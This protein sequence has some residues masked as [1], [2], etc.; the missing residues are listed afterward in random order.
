MELTRGAEPRAAVAALYAEL[1]KVAATGLDERE[2]GR[3][4][5]NLAAHLLRELATNNG[6][7]HALGT[8][9]LM[10][11]TWRAGLELAHRY[12]Q[13]SLAEV[14][15]AA[16]RFLE[17]SRRSVVTLVPTAAVAA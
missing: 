10:L 12:Q 11:G 14:Q 1:E 15:A 17:P 13:V 16:R 2:L 6:R 5:N 4:K 9:E 7:A 8:Y 3:A